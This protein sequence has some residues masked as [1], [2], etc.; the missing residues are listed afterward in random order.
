MAENTPVSPETP[1]DPKGA[2]APGGTSTPDRPGVVKTLKDKLPISR[3][4]SPYFLAALLTA[5]AMG[6]YFF[7][8]VPQKLEY[9]VGQRFR[10]LAVAS[11]QIKSKSESLAGSL[12]IAPARKDE[13][14]A[15]TAPAEQTKKG[16]QATTAPPVEDEDPTAKYLRLLVPEIQLGVNGAAPK[17]TGLQLVVTHPDTDP[18]IKLSATVAWDRV[19]SQAAAASEGEFDD[20]VVADKSGQVV[21]QREKTT[22]RLGNLTELLY[23]DDDKGTLMSPSW[24]VRT[25]FPAVD[26]KKG[27]PK[28]ATLKP[29]RI[30]ATSTWMLV[31]VVHLESVYLADSNQTTLYVAGFVS[32]ERLQAQAMR[33]PLAWLIVVWLPVAVLFLALPFIK[34]ATMNTK[35]RFSIVNL[36]LMAIGTIAAAGLAAALPVGPRSVSAVEDKVL[37]NVATEIDTRL[38][39]ETRA[40]LELAKRVVRLE[41]DKPAKDIQEKRGCQVAV[42]PWDNETPCN[43]W[44]RLDGLLS[45]PAPVPELDVVIWLNDRGEQFRKWTTKAQVTGKTPHRGFEHFQNLTSRSLWSVSPAQGEVEKKPIKFTIEPLRAPTTA[46]L[47]VVF[48]MPLTDLLEASK[49]PDPSTSGADVP[50]YLALNIRPHAVVDPVLPPGY[51]FAIVAPD[52]KVL[53]HSS[54][55]LSLEENFFEEVSNAQGVRE[56]MQSGRGETWS[57]DYHGTPHRI[58][59]QPASKLTGCL[60]KIVTFQDLNPRLASIV[61]HQSGTFRLGALNLALLLV[62]ALV[63]WWWM[64]SGSRDF[65]DLMTATRSPDP[66]R[67]S[68]LVVLMV[69]T[70][71]ALAATQDPRAHRWADRL[72]L[73]FVALP[74]M[75]VAVS[76]YSRW[77]G[78]SRDDGDAET[79]RVL[80]W[81]V[82][83]ELAMVVLL[84]GAAPAAGFARIVQRVLDVQATERWLEAAHQRTV[85]HADRARARAMS[86]GY[87]EATRTSLAAHR[88]FQDSPNPGLD[89]KDRTQLHFYVS[90]PMLDDPRPEAQCNTAPESGHVLYAACST[91]RCSRRTAAEIPKSKRVPNRTTCRSVAAAS[92]WRRRSR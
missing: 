60:W 42:T 27:L 38:A 45:G 31:Q 79:P 40:V 18:P 6:W 68:G 30:G 87:A 70:L 52:G 73:F 71:F 29:V 61:D 69:L 49:I 74:F 19:A 91:G 50:R 22:P 72:Y 57:G 26:A 28:T 80:A 20:L 53:F 67:L 8:F 4:A 25:V 13:K 14:K 56:R 23:A 10:T 86:P 3:S 41:E 34:L 15:A 17:S 89:R 11:G 84:V 47:G 32:R 33:I 44:S 66:V 2:K 37:E 85:A 1:R 75:A 54:D 90:R 48:A 55:G 81:L 63:A 51:G 78:V 46:E 64:R 16:E 24:A 58:H 21:W 36:M 83:L 76:V 62:V 77:S 39:E 82:S 12:N 88:T 92:R 35:E 43:L 59:V 5:A 9:F 7:L 65:R